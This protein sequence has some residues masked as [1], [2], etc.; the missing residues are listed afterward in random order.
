[1]LEFIRKRDGRL[2]PFEGEKI[3]GAIAKA[4]QAVGG[5]DM[6]KADQIGRQVIG[7]LEVIYSYNFV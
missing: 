7:I 3:N 2:V 6:H 1:M 5:Q 4:V